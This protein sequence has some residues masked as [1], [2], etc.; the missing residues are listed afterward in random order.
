MTKVEQIEQEIEQLSR[1]EFA[2]LRDWILE[3]DWASWDAQVTQDV[4][5][6]KLDELVSESQEDYRAGRMREL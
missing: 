4:R 5:A 6:G 1:S 3:R 2:L